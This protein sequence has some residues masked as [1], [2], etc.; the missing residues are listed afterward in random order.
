MSIKMRAAP[1]AVARSMNGRMRP[2][3]GEPGERI[4][5]DHVAQAI[6]RLEQFP[7]GVAQLLLAA[8]RNRGETAQSEDQLD[9]G[10]EETMKRA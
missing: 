8:I 4:G 2:S 3:V 1:A 6:L 5:V 7:V 10:I 9:P